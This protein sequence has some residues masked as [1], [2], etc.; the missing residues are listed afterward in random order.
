MQ[1]SKMRHAFFVSFLRFLFHLCLFASVVTKRFLRYFSRRGFETHI[2]N[3]PSHVEALFKVLFSVLIFPVDYKHCSC[4]F[5]PVV[6]FFFLSFRVL[7]SLCR[8]WANSSSMERCELFS[9][10]LLL[11]RRLGIFGWDGKL[12]PRN[13]SM[14][15]PALVREGCNLRRIIKKKKCIDDSIVY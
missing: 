5:V 12:S 9:T 8:L 14:Q 7:P 6:C 1:G 13:D 15:S 4:L 2:C 3:L 10:I 11:S